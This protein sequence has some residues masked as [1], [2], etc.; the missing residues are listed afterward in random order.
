MLKEMEQEGGWAGTG[1]AG[2]AGSVGLLTVPHD[3]DVRANGNVLEG[4]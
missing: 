4:G 1:R 3:H 2:W